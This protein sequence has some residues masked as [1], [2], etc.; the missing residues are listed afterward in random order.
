MWIKAADLRQWYQT[1]IGRITKRVLRRRLRRLLPVQQPEKVLVI[2][3]AVPYMRLFRHADV[4]HLCPKS[5]GAIRFPE[6]GQSKTLLSYEDEMPF[7]EDTFDYV[8]VCHGLEFAEHPRQTLAEIWRVLKSQGKVLLMAPNRLSPWSR[9]EQ[10]PF[11]KGKP[12]S[13]GELNMLLKEQNYLM[14]QSGF[15]L[16]FPPSSKKLALKFFDLFEKIGDRWFAMMGGVV[17]IEAKKNLFGGQPVKEMR[18]KEKLKLKPAL[19][20]AYKQQKSSR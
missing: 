18:P 10:T 17:L 13:A 16:Y 4:V 8:F 2:G 3:Y 15:G 7:K 5:L 6:E 9:I 12:Y 1:E 11:A 20:T 19:G 14:T